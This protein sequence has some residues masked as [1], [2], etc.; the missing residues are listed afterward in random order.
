M[1]YFQVE[2]TDSARREIRQLPGNMR[3]L[4]FREIQSLARETKPYSS[5]TLRSTKNFRVPAGLE[6]RRIRIE[7]W[8]IVYAIEKELDLVT[9]LAVR[10]RPPYQYDDLTG[11]LRD[12]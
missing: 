10:K 11:L 8:R 5:K 3:Q 2:F 12:I 6:I 7:Q 1:G 9:V 4:I